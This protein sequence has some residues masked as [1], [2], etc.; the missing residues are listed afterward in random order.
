[1]NLRR[2]LLSEI[3][4]AKKSVM[5]MRELYFV[6]GKIRMAFDLDAITI[7]ECMELNHK[8]VAEGINNPKYFE[9]T[10]L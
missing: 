9:R 7:D 1:M 3:E 2:D 6:Y 4:N 5:P 10:E 8:C